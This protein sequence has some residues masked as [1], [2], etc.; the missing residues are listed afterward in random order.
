[1]KVLIVFATVE[2]QTRKIALFAEKELRTAGHDV[3]LF[4][5]SDKAAAVSF[6]GVDKVILAASVHERRHPATFEVFLAAHRDELKARSTLLLSVSLNASF[7]EG[8]EEAGEYV[9]EMEMRTKFTPDTKALIA[10]AVRTRN[11]DY[12]ASQVVRHVVLRGRDY[13]PSDGEHEFTDWTQLKQILSA[14]TNA[15]APSKRAVK[16]A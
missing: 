11:Y 7:P 16:E 6:E 15:D 14:F 13:N 2:G 9:T 10:G 1:M 4:N 3:A 5:T 12:F 8:V